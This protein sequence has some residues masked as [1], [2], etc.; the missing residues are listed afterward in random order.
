MITLISGLNCFHLQPSQPM[1][2]AILS[3]APLFIPIFEK[4][5]SIVC[6]IKIYGL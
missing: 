3:V 5:Q 1:G 4:L 6:K 2:K